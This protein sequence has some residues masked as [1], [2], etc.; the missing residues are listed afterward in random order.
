MSVGRYEFGGLV[1]K[2][3]Y[4]YSTLL[5]GLSGRMGLF[6]GQPRILTAIKDN[7]GCTL[8]DLSELTGVGMPSLSVSVRNLTK[9]GLIK[10]SKDAPHRSRGLYLTET[11][12]EKAE[13]FHEEIDRF[14]AE[15]FDLAG[16]KVDGFSEALTEF[17]SFTDK[18]YA[19]HCK[20]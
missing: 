17:C 12:T 14:F 19:E 13:A 2:F 3:L 8:S 16:E 1:Y 15:Y 10:N 6:S 9:A 5:R 18:Y 20:R 4:S 7:P 11:G